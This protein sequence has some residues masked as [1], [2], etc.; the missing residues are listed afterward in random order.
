MCD[1]HSTVDQQGDTTP[2]QPGDT[3][4][5]LSRRGFIYG[6]AAL[7]ASA[8]LLREFP[9][10]PL[11]SAERAVASDGS[12]AFSMAMHVHS[13]FSEQNGS[14]QAQLFQAAT[15]SIDVLWWTDHDQRMDGLDYRDVVHFTS[16][17]NEHPAPGQGRA[18]HWQKVES[19]PLSRKSGGG[20]VSTPYSPNDPV[21]FGSLHLAAQ[22]TGSAAASY[23]YYADSKPAA[24]NYRDNL[25]GQSLNIDVLL[26][27][28][29]TKGYLELFIATSYHEASGGR[30][31]GVYALSYRFVPPGTAAAGPGAHGLKGV[32]TIPVTPS[33][34]D[35]WYTAT[36][37]PCDDI[38]SLWPDLDYRDFGLWGLTLNAVS[39]GDAV[40]GY[41]D[42]LRFNRSI[43]GEAFLQQQEH[44]GSFLAPQYPS[45]VQQLGLEVSWVPPHVNWFGPNV[46]IPDYGKTTP[47][48]WTKYLQDTLVPQVHNAGGLVS[49]NHP[50]GFGY[51]RAQSQQKQDQRL[52][53]L[54][55]ELLPT[56]SAPAVLGSDLLEVGYPL[57][58]GVDLAHHVALWDIMSRNA[59]FLTG[60]G[61]NDDHYGKDW[62]EIPNNWFTSAW[63]PSTKMPDLLAALAA[64]R[65]W[66]ASMSDFRGSLNLLVD[67][68]CPMG[69]VSVSSVT[70]RKLVASAGGLEPGTSLQV[71]QG[72]VDY[73]GTSALAAN[74]R[75]IGSYPATDFSRGSITQTIDTSKESFVR[76]QVVDKRG[77]VVSLS[78]PI[79]LLR[80]TPPGGI[81]PARAVP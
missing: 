27:S 33:G 80:K 9:R 45:V 13:S 68:I 32:I 62:L 46:V 78:N 17:T 73:A 76:T 79:W 37:T 3:G 5:Q 38:A 15:N 14:M 64:G 40:A 26:E 43:S 47:H 57:R 7:A 10:L 28:G 67:G 44:M 55:K 39:T 22:S 74:T 51:G 8:G 21:P 31:A 70:S 75:L 53:R 48:T 4:Q 34:R 12:P 19:G 63:A 36:I 71:L 6:T 56:A 11:H 35:P 42:Y 2:T 41:F 20:I 59:V 18:W 69:S 60:N 24:W 81:P 50:F 58:A 1:D 23:G 77:T 65:A 25:T 29:W 54:A 16:L 30:P 49:Y 66:C 72:T 61:A 52:R